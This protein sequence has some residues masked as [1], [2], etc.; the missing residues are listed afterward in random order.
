V[1]DSLSPVELSL[2]HSKSQTNRL[3]AR[4]IW[5]GAIC[6]ARTTL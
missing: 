6:V 1:H 2:F 4:P 3:G 5:F